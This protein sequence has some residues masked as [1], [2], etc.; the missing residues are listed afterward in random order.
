MNRYTT[1]QE[2]VEYV[3]ELTFGLGADVVLE[4]AGVP[5]AFSE[6]LKLVRAGG[7]LVEFGHFS[8]VGTT[9]LNPQDI[10]N[11]DLDIHGVFAYPNTQIDI[12]LRTL[13]YTKDRF[14]YKELITHR[15]SVEQTEEA[16]RAGRD[17]SCVKA[18]VINPV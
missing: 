7:K 16:I 15:F 5:A 2:R 6:S 18:M 10:V 17:K 8:N 4:M 11:K 9:P 14:P 3:R 13:Q 1:E 12:A